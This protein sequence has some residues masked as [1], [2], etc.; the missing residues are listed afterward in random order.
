MKRFVLITGLVWIWLGQDWSLAAQQSS[1]EMLAA[2][3]EIQEFIRTTSTRLR[4]LEEAVK[5]Q[6]RILVDLQEQN[7]KLQV[8]LMRLGQSN[9]AAGLDEDIKRL[10]EDIK[11][12]DRKRLSDNKLT[13]EQLRRIESIIK[14]GPA[15]PKPPP[16]PVFGN[17]TELY[18]Y[19]IQ[20]GDTLTKIVAKLRAEGRSVTQ[21]AI[22]SAN[23]TVVWTKMQ[24]GQKLVI[25][26]SKD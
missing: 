1:L 2:R 18:E 8:E 26:V 23:P 20:S 16:T 11:Q 14:A 15:I 25:P 5:D 24:I 9:P 21:S 10:A 3:Q 13:M 4:D 22:Q 19:E 6:Q 7:R 12:V 17:D